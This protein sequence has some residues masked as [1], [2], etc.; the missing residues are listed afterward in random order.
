M[1]A[2]AATAAAAGHIPTRVIL[3]LDLDSYY[4]QVECQRLGLPHHLPLAVQQWSG[5]I[6]VNYPARAAGLSKMSSV[7]QAAELLPDCTLVHV[8]TIDRA[9]V[10]HDAPARS[11]RDVAAA[12]AVGGGGAIG[13]GRAPSQATDKSSL[14]RYRTASLDIFRLLVGLVGSAAV[15]KVRRREGG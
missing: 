3:H 12:T 5:L 8:E 15:E 1:D 4:A 7:K 14:S 11:A 2:A 9:G 10:S 6:A 13:G